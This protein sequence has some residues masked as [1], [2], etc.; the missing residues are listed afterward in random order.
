MDEPVALS[1]S[2]VFEI[3]Q[4]AVRVAP[5]E[6]CGLILVRGDE[7]RV[8]RAQNVQDLVRALDRAEPP[9]TEAYTVD[10]TTLLRAAAWVAEGWHVAAIYHSHPNGYPKLSERDTAL[11]APDGQPLYPEVDYLLAS[12]S[13]E[14][15]RMTAWRWDGSGFRQRRI[16]CAGKLDRAEHCGIA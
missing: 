5:E 7:R 12:L 4:H 13:G 9:A 11:A 16:W 1:W 15:V 6:A 10:P 8:L 3:R 2:E 14:R